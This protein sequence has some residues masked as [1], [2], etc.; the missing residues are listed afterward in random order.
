MTA[1][2][3]AQVTAT[4]VAT[5]T[6]A[7]DVGLTTT[8]TATAQLWVT[9][10]R[11]ALALTKTVGTAAN[12]CA[13]TGELAVWEGTPVFYCYTAQNSGNVTLTTHS[14]A[15]SHLGLLAASVA[16]ELA[17]GARIVV[18]APHTAQFT[19]TNV[20]TWT[21]A[22]ATGVTTTVTDTAQLW[23]TPYRPGLVLTKTVGT[24]ADQCATTGELAVWEGT[25]VFYCYTAQNTGNVTLTTHS[26]ADSHLGLLAAS[27]AREL[28]PGARI[29]VTAAHTAQVMATNV[30][31]WTAATATGETTTV[32][33]TAQL[34]VT[35]Y[36]PG[37]VLT[38]TVGTV[39]DQCA[40]TGELAV[41]EGTPVFYCYTAQNTGN[42]TLTTHS[43]A[44]SQLGL[45][46][47]RV[48]HVLAPGARIVV[49]AAHT[50]Q[51]TATNVA[52]WTAATATGVTITVKDTAQATVT[53]TPHRPAIL[54]AKTVGTQPGVCAA[55]SELT[56]APGTTVY[57]CYTATNVGSMMLPY[58]QLYDTELGDLLVGFPY[59][60]A[61]G[62]SLSTVD[63]G[64]VISTAMMSTTVNDGVWTAYADD[65]HFAIASDRATVRTGRAALA[66]SKAVALDPRQCG[67]RT[68]LI[69]RPGAA[70]SLLCHTAERWQCGVR[71]LCAGGSRVGSAGNRRP[72][73]PA[74]RQAHDRRPAT[75]VAR[76]G[77]GQR[78]HH[79]HSVRHLDH[80]VGW[81]AGC[82]GGWRIREGCRRQQP[83]HCDRPGCGPGAGGHRW[84]HCARLHRRARRPRRRRR[85]QPRGFGLRR[86]WS[87]G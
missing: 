37:L 49:T 56:V 74:G 69:V 10:Y 23:V 58:H 17:P 64:L 73:A 15:D 13:A 55:T 59:A 46:V 82:R 41:W 22:T 60:L 6:A 27:V 21:A 86:R 53:V 87:F 5:W 33:D 61:P 35:P 12:E 36:R 3:T 77:D 26:L 71:A 66:V 48:A 72:A 68:M 42:V 29:V 7:T 32:T 62:Q 25:P 63:I 19:A 54:V 75:G 11:P 9:P 52:T 80:N 39:A 44:D 84:G 45:L 65:D 51:V 78:R 50:A 40:T 70:G 57:F 18:T 81:R 16:R 38:K 47:D 4:N 14:L 20:A 43:L 30:A 85:T 79:Q 28:A 8:A 31:T 1:A 2:H 67:G 76:P 34:W 24:V 83:V